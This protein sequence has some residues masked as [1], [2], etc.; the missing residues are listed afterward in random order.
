MS[1][2]PTLLLSDEEDSRTVCERIEQLC[3]WFIGNVACGRVNF[4][5]CMV[6]RSSSNAIEDSV[7][8]AVLLGDEVTSRTLSARSAKSI[9]QL[10]QVLQQVHLLLRERR[11]ISQRELYYLL[12]ESFSCQEQLNGVVLDA[13][14]VLGVPRYALNI[15]AATR[16][17]V[18]GCLRIATANSLYHVDCE[19]VGSVCM[20]GCVL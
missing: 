12:I 8:G 2:F 11:R 18:A 7:S 15:G 17:V 3:C 6:K 9:S 16:G 4:K 13:S 20:Q 19:Y 14:A 1:S 10:F 5:I